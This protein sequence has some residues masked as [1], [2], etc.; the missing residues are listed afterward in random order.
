[1]ALNYIINVFYHFTNEEN[2]VQ[3]INSVVNNKP[4]GL[5]EAIFKELYF[6]T[7]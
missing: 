3:Q 1:M 4:H 7:L 6:V 2:L 5:S